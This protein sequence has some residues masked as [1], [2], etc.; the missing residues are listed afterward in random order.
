MTRAQRPTTRSEHDSSAEAVRHAPVSQHPSALLQSV[1]TANDVSKSQSRRATRQ[2][3]DEAGLADLLAL[4]EAVLE[5]GCK[6]RR[7]TQYVLV[8]VDLLVY[9]T[10]DTKP[11]QNCSNA[12]TPKPQ[13]ARARE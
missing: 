10:P 4:A 3:N 13:R 11:D 1:T 12:N 8:R 9:A 5:H 2:Q 6:V 7:P